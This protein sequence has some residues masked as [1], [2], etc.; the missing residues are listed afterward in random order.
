MRAF[1]YV[2][3]PISGMAAYLSSNDAR[4]QAHGLQSVVLGGVWPLA[5]WLASVIS[6]TATRAIFICFLVLWVAMLLTAALGRD[7][8]IPWLRTAIRD[9]R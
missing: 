2:L 8:M 5:L 6:A 7:V 9:E 1:A 3:P 4:T